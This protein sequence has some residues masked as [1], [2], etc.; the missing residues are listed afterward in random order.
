MIVSNVCT[1]IVQTSFK[2]MSKNI[3]IMRRLLRMIIVFL[4]RLIKYIKHLSLV[5]HSRVL[6][7]RL[8]SCDRIFI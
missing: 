3:V 8:V 7:W 5:L 6:L 2:N 4:W 1:E